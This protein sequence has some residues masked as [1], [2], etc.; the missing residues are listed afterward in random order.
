MEALFKQV[1]T[2]GKVEHEITRFSYG[3]KRTESGKFSFFY[4]IIL[5]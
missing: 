3:L 2:V 5:E 4:N 1:S